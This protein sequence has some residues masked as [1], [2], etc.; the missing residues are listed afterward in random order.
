MNIQ[1]EFEYWLRRDLS[2][3]LYLS[4]SKQV[5]MDIKFYEFANLTAPLARKAPQEFKLFFDEFKKIIDEVHKWKCPSDQCIS[6]AM[7]LDE[8][9][10]VNFGKY[11]NGKM[12]YKLRPKNKSEK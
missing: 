4:K 3:K 12:V 11:P 1:H 5:A 2:W 9:G 6:P 8:D 10:N 7:T